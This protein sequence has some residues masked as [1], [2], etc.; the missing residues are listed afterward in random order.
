MTEK[1]KKISKSNSSLIKMLSWLVVGLC[2]IFIIIGFNLHKNVYMPILV[3]ILASTVSLYNLE[4]DDLKK[5]DSYNLYLA[6]ALDVIALV[7][8]FLQSMGKI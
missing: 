8:Y 6:A 2:V 7:L 1:N 3:M 5:I 4:R